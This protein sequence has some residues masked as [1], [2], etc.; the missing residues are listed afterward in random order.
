MAV[1]ITRD[2]KVIRRSRNLRGL[3]TH[4]GKHG[5]NEVSVWRTSNGAGVYVKFGDGA[6]CRTTFADFTIARD[7]FRKRWQKWGLYAEV[8]NSDNYWS[9]I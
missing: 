9:F 1:E 4:A 2:G 5:V 7:F 3:I 8:R 6:T